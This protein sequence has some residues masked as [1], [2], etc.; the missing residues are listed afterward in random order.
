M[1]NKP[2]EPRKFKVEYKGP[3]GARYSHGVAVVEAANEHD[4]EFQ[5]NKV[6][7]LDATVTTITELIGGQ[8]G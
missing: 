5:A 7:P 8:R 3:A 2:V 1:E 4:A 6:V